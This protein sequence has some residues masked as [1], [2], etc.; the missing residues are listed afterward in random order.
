MLIIDEEATN[1]GQ[2][3][4][5]RPTELK[6]CHI[7]AVMPGAVGLSPSALWMHVVFSKIV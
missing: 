6:V 1:G 3:D 2:G 7:L 4:M 5:D